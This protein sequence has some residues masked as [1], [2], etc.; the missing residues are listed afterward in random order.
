MPNSMVRFH[1]VLIVEQVIDYGNVVW[2]G[3]TS[4]S[5][6]TLD[7]IEQDIEIDFKQEGLKRI[8]ESIL[9]KLI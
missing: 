8:K 7:Q 9:A 6:V 3:F 5:Y 4:N 2:N 1:I